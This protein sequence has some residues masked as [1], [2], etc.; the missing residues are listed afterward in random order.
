MLCTKS[1]VHSNT[2]ASH[3]SREMSVFSKLLNRS[4]IGPA[5]FLH[6]CR[7]KVRVSEANAKK[8]FWDAIFAH[9]VSQNLTDCLKL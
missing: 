9:A 7:E 2:Y 1:R 8:I 5:N 4:E 3:M 6:N